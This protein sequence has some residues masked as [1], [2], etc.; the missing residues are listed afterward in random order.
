MSH[1]SRTNQKSQARTCSGPRLLFSNG[2][3][4]MKEASPRNKSGVTNLGY[5]AR[6]D[7]AGEARAF[8]ACLAGPPR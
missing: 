1:V 5:L 7:K 8:R 4:G 6:A 2:A 3:P